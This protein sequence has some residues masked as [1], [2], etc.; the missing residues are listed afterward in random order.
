[1]PLTLVHVQVKPECID[2]F[3]AATM[4]NVTQSRKE[5]G[6]WQFDLCQQ[7]D[8]PARFVIVE[9]Y[10]TAEAMTAHKETAHYMKWRDAAAGMMAAPRFGVRYEKIAAVR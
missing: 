7:S 8:D 10:H 5:S 6:V 3:K 9:G 2:A 1:M 4:D